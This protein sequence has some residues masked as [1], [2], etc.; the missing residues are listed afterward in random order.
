MTDSELIELCKEVLDANP[1]KVNNYKLGKKNLIAFFLGLVIKK[2]KPNPD[3]N[4]N[5]ILEASRILK[6]LDNLLK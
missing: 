5:P 4:N 2:I 3:N 6:T 1:D